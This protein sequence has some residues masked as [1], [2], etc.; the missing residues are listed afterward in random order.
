MNVI[1]AEECDNQDCFSQ[2]WNNCY[3]VIAFKFIF[4]FWSNLYKCILG[5][6]VLFLF[7]PIPLR[8]AKTLWSFGHSE[9]NRVKLSGTMPVSILQ[10][11]IV[12][13]SVT[14]FKVTWRL[15]RL[16]IYKLQF[17]FIFCIFLFSWSQYCRKGEHF[18]QRHYW[19]RDYKKCSCSTQLSTK[20]SLLIKV[21]MLTFLS[22]LNIYKQEK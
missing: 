20:L 15:R 7:N 10:F 21:K 3:S 17:M 22:I 14:I 9:C 1:I 11:I 19:P 16:K 18:C 6:V 8:M 4:L 13:C 5:Q 12:I 2:S